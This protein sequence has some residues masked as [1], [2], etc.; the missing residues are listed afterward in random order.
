MANLSA[1]V[2]AA[3]ARAAA[4]E[5]LYE[6]AAGWSNRRLMAD[7]HAANG[8]PPPPRFE[9]RFGQYP[10]CTTHTVHLPSVHR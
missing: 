1:I 10:Q 5:Q 4:L 2:P 7:Y 3:L 9:E 6:Q 8:R